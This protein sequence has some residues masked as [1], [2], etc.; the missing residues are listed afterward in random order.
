MRRERTPPPYDHLEQHHTVRVQSL[1][2]DQIQL[3]H[4]ASL[5]ILER[6]GVRFHSPEAVALC[7]AAGAQVTDGN[8]VRLPPSR[9]EWALR[10]APQ[11]IT[12]FN[13]LGQRAMFLGGYR[14]Y[15]GP[16][17][18]APHIYD[19]EA[20]QRRLAVLADV[21]QS[22]RL[23]DALPNLDFVMSQ[24][25]PSD[26]AA[27]RYERAQ[28]ATMFQESVKPV[29]FVGLEQASTI[30]AIA[31]ASAIAGNV[32]NLARYPFVVNYVNFA[33]P[34]NH[35]RESMERL[36]YAAER[37]IPSVYTPGRAR[38]SEVPMTE[39]GALSLVNAGQ[40]AGLVLAQLK[41]EG[42]PFIWA[43]PGSGALDMSTMVSLFASPDAGPSS[44]D[45]AHHYGLPIFGF[46]GASE[47][48]VFDG[49][50]AAEAAL[51]LFQNALHGANLVHDI[52]LLD[53]GLTGSLELVALADEVI[54]WLRAYLRQLEITTDTLAPDLIRQVGPDSTFLDTEHTL[55]HVHRTWR[56]ALFDRNTYDRW[57]A[58]GALDLQTRA[59]RKIQDILAHHRAEPL[60]PATAEALATI[61]EAG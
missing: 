57:S 19:L 58:K 17:S 32:E 50:A 10:A 30:H 6:T 9:V 35:N 41:R 29:V 59:Q 13:R 39:A 43:N 33:T 11:N 22:A 3:L 45:V 31:M 49:Q 60:D 53:S 48:K 24:Y 12:L 14:S 55:R 8:L 16:G 54:G 20:G 37:N 40:L 7:Q 46:A 25:L 28:L 26:V 36:L 61:V 1:S 4:T 42:S 47:A 18:D 5:E 56:P 52:G 51:T 34:F 27:D 44:W 15:Y 23:V 38:G 21:A 2:D